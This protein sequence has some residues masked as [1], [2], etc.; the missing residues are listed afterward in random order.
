MTI[1]LCWKN[2]SY[3]K[4]TYKNNGNY[5][6][7]FILKYGVVIHI[8]VRCKHETYIT[9]GSGISAYNM[10]ICSNCDEF[11]GING[12]NWKERLSKT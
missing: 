10:W 5:K 4:N 11:E 3:G 1:K 12:E 9:S 6:I 8:L 7:V 2:T